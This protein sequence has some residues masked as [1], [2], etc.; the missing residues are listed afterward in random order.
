LVIQ[1]INGAQL[2]TFLAFFIGEKS[3]Y[4]FF[5][6]LCVLL[7]YFLCVQLRYIG[8]HAESAKIFAKGTK[9]KFPIIKHQFVNWQM[10]NATFLFLPSLL[11]SI[12]H[13]YNHFADKV[14]T[15]SSS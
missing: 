3:S 1:D 13:K 11:G 15:V 10:K 7:L 12:I 6:G 4:Y 2:L 5:G 8:F 14:L 9:F